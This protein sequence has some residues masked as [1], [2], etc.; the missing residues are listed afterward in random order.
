MQI[1][2]RNPLVCE[3]LAA[4]DAPNG[5]Q[6]SYH[7][8]ELLA[9]GAFIIICKGGALV[10]GCTDCG[11]VGGGFIEGDPTLPAAF[12]ILYGEVYDG[13]PVGTTTRVTVTV[14]IQDIAV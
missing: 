7:Y 6:F 2:W 12:D 5:C 14:T 13:N 9:E 10:D 8:Y 1:I 11:P 4:Q 3:Y